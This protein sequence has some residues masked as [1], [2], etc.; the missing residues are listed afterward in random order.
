[1]SSLR[2]RAYDNCCSDEFCSCALSLIL[3]SILHFESLNF[4]ITNF[5]GQPRPFLAPFS[6]RT[7]VK[8]AHQ[9][10]QPIL[11]RVPQPTCSWTSRCV[12]VGEPDYQSSLKT[13]LLFTIK[14]VYR[15]TLMGLRFCIF[16]HNQ[17]PLD[18][19]IFKIRQGLPKCL[20]HQP[21]G[22]LLG[23]DHTKPQS[24]NPSVVSWILLLK[25]VNICSKSDYH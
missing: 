25:S 8:L 12:S 22:T 4:L 18:L 11:S 5:Q 21:T 9:P 13:N 14:I 10:R 24:R 23:K 1:M 2:H 3:L 16:V 19:L 17:F 6:F 7:S 15:K 20:S